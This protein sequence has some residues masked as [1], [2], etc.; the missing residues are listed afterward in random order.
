M[1]LD[2]GPEWPCVEPL[3]PAPEASGWPALKSVSTPI[4]QPLSAEERAGF[5]AI[6]MQY[7]AAEAC[8][9]FFKKRFGSNTDED[10]DEDDNGDDEDDE[11]SEEGSEENEEFRF[12]LKMFVEDSEL[13]SHFEKNY[14]TGDFCCLVCRGIGKKGWKR[15][16][17]CVGVVQHSIT[18]SKTKRKRAHRAFG[19]VVCKVLGWDIDRFPTIILKD[20]PLGRSLA[21]PVELQVI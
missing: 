16:K 7:K 6:Q 12:F 1:P 21:K 17:G 13:R 3:E 19:Q 15:F 20:E 18:I 14:E 4:G 5:A 11:M 8:R 9:E 10:E 2:S